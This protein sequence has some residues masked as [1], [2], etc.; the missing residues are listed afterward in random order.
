MPA[1]ERIAEIVAPGNQ[2]TPAEAEDRG[3]QLLVRLHVLGLHGLDAEVRIQVRHHRRRPDPEQRLMANLGP[4]GGGQLPLH[5]DRA[6]HT[7]R[8]EQ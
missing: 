6:V 2:S 5:A 7:F 1:R 8:E 3:L 4:I